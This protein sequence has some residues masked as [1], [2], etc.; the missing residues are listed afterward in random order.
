M[1]PD[2]F[3]YGQSL[4][5]NCYLLGEI[6]EDVYLVYSYPEH[7]FGK[8]WAKT[9]MFKTVNII[10]KG[11]NFTRN[12]QDVTTKLTTKDSILPQGSQYKYLALHPGAFKGSFPYLLAVG[13]DDS[14]SIKKFQII[15]GYSAPIA[16]DE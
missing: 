5:K 8:W 6:D 15:D 14:L 9:G 12:Y 13:R 16:V 2:G 4:R 7:S 3:K 11:S 10:T 1:T